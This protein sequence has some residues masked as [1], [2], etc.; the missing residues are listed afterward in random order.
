[1]EQLSRRRGDGRGRVVAAEP[2]GAEDAHQDCLRLGPAGRAVAL[3]VLPHDHGRSHL[4]LG[5]VVVERDVRLVQEREQ[6]V[7]VA[8]DPLA[9]PPGVGVGVQA[10]GRVV[11][12]FAQ[13]AVDEADAGP[14]RVGREGTFERRLLRRLPRPCCM[15]FTLFSSPF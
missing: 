7:A 15:F 14:V 8:A 5:V 2:Q 10:A 12:Q 11:G 6:V 1:M 4:P 9:Q 13:P 3:D